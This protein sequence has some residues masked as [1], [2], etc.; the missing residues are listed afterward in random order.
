MTL[1]RAIQQA[2]ESMCGREGVCA[3]VPRGGWDGGRGEETE[4]EGGGENLGGERLIDGEPR[5][6]FIASLDIYSLTPNP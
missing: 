2:C 1:D 3:R 4:G 6:L 5:A